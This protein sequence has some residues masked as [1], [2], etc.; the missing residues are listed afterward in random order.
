MESDQVHFT[1]FN[2]G[3]CYWNVIKD[4][5]IKIS[6]FVRETL[7]M[8]LLDSACSWTVARKL[9]FDIFFDTLNNQDKH[10]VKNC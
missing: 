9:W 1:L 7:D 5:I 3:T 4:L 2:V 6:K 10:L 8:A